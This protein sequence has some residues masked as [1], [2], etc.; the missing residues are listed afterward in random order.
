MSARRLN[1][2]RKEMNTGRIQEE[3]EDEVVEKKQT[4]NGTRREEDSD[5]D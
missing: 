5:G 4:V 1:V 3:E 2:E